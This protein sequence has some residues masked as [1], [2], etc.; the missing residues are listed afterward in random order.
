MDRINQAK[1]DFQD[2]L[3]RWQAALNEPETELNRDAAILRFELAYE[4]G[5]KLI[6]ITARDEGYEVKSP[7]EAF[8]TAFSLDWVSDEVIWREILHARN[9]ATHVYRESYA[10]SLYEQLDE[11]HKAFRELETAIIAFIQEKEK[12]EKEDNDE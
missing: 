12:N 9:R 2:I 1:K 4:V 8:Q 10:K 3:E 5:W 6:Q 7:R 11:Y